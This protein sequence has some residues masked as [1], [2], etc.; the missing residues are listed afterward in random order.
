MKKAVICIEK[1][2][3]IIMV[4]SLFFTAV[5]KNIATVFIA[6]N[7]PTVCCRIQVVGQCIEIFEPQ[8]YKNR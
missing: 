2:N 8:P 1:A 6:I 3:D 5:T 7:T 4:I